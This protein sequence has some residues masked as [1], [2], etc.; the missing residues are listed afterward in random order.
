T[1]AATAALERAGALRIVLVNAGLVVCAVPVPGAVRVLVS[2]LVLAGLAA[3]LPLLAAAIRASRRAK[4]ELR[5]LSRPAARS[6]P[7]R[8]EPDR[9]GRSSGLAASGLAAVALAVA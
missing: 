9:R 7:S 6:R 8:T 1:R 5:A 2:T 4:Q 3:F